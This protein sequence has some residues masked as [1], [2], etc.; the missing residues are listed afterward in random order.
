MRLELD[1]NFNHIRVRGFT[2]SGAPFAQLVDL[3]DPK[4]SLLP[5][6]ATYFAIFCLATL[7]R[8]K[9]SDGMLFSWDAEARI[10]LAGFHRQHASQRGEPVRERP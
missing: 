5:T 7:N 8:V 1:R 10:Y 4:A 9:F 2:L 6:A 3:N